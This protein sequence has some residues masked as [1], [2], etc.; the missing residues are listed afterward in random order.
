[1]RKVIGDWKETEARKFARFTSVQI[2]KSGPPKND[3]VSA[4]AKY[5]SFIFRCQT[6]AGEFRL[7]PASEPSPYALCFAIF[8][9]HLLGDKESLEKNAEAWAHQLLQ[10]LQRAQGPKNKKPYLQLLTFTLSA[11]SI[12]KPAALEQLRAETISLLEQDMEK[13]LR[14]LGVAEGKPGSGNMAMFQA[15]LL[16]FAQKYLGLPQEEKIQAW[17]HFHLQAM[18]ANGFW[19][20]ESLSPYLQFQNGYHQYEIFEYLNILPRGAEK[21]SRFVASLADGEG[22]FAPYPGGGGCYD[23]DAIFLLTFP[24]TGSDA[25]SLLEKTWNSLLEEQNPDGGFCESRFARARQWKDL[26]KVIGHLCEMGPGKSDRL[27]KTLSTLLKPSRARI[28]THWTSYSR[29]WNES[30]LWDSWFRMQTL[31][32]IETAKNPAKLKEWGFIHFP[33]IGFHHGL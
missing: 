11:L 20:A 8:G 21:A 30:N 4:K 7:C 31:A 33:G 29:H 13:H 17:S 18:N 15:I 5:G 12:V 16:I 28:P 23:Y 1:M 27:K 22:H 2:S 24:R 19:G 32:R 26:G 3:L 25:D 10:N 14:S 9:L 6:E